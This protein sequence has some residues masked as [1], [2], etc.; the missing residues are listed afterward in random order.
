MIDKPWA[1][2]RCKQK[3]RGKGKYQDLENREGG[4]D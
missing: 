3:P 2:G 1:R 4:G